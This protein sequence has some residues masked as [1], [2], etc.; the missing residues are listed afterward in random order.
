MA[1]LTRTDLARIADAFKIRKSPPK[2]SVMSPPYAE[3]VPTV[4]H[5]KLHPANGEQLRFL[6]IATDGCELL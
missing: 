6:I 5:R 2:P 4:T 3:P 1:K